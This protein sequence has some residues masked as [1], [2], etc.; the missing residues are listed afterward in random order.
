MERYNILLPN[1]M[2][3]ANIPVLKGSISINRGN[4]SKQ[5]LM[6]QGAMK[7]KYYALVWWQKSS[8]IKRWFER[9]PQSQL[10]NATGKA[11]SIYF[12]L[13]T[14]IILSCEMMKAFSNKSLA[15][16]HRQG[17]YNINWNILDGEKLSLAEFPVSKAH[18]RERHSS[19]YSI[20]HGTKQSRRKNIKTKHSKI[21]YFG[22]WF[23]SKCL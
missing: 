11:F 8:L 1:M 6:S 23:F 15:D 5:K 7:A 21:S 13:S 18:P 14:V 12:W 2:I 19:L 20:L 3:I 4:L 16:T 22:V 10:G 9:M 17:D